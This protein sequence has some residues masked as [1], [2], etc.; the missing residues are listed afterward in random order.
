MSD[1]LISLIVVAFLLAVSFLL[2]NEIRFTH[3]NLVTISP[4]QF[5]QVLL[6]RIGANPT[7]GQ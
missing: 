4:L 1:P 3:G 7:D 5:D 6:T 2:V